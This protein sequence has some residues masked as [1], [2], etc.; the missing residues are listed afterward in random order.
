MSV[1]L[2]S[3]FVDGLNDGD[4]R[5][6]ARALSQCLGYCGQNSAIV[7][8]LPAVMDVVL[9]QTV[10]KTNTKKKGGNHFEAEEAED[11]ARNKPGPS[12]AKQ[13]ASQVQAHRHTDPHRRQLVLG[14]REQALQAAPEV[15]QTLKSMMNRAMQAQPQPFMTV[16]STVDPAKIQAVQNA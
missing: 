10:A 14:A 5:E 11:E 16:L 9:A 3:E 1:W 13:A 15:L 8:L 12:D 4:R 7:A 6:V 2:R